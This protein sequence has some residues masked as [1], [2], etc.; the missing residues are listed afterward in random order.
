MPV[1]QASIGVGQA[2]KACCEVKGTSGEASAHE[3]VALNIDVRPVGFFLYGTLMDR[4]V[5]ARVVD[6]LV[7]DHELLPALLHGFQRVACENFVYPCLVE[8]VGTRT[9]GVVL[10]N[11]TIRDLIR[12]QWFEADE[13][14]P[15]TAHV[16]LLDGPS[17]TVAYFS[18]LD[19][20]I[21]P[22][23][24]AWCPATW[25]SRHKSAY[26]TC[27]DEW[28]AGCPDVDSAY[29]IVCTWPAHAASPC[30]NTVDQQA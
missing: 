27:C 9:S 28:M 17:A 10:M 4:D 2:S 26:L 16:V 29:P 12:M 19:E 30:S 21:A 24:Q 3:S 13:Y 11:P 1:A 25:S 15:S 7:A 18:P 6:R 22:T 14:V 5:L 8:D 20:V 23:A